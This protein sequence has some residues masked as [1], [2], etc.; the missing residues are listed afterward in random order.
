[1]ELKYK[2]K[3]EAHY[4]YIKGEYEKD[5]ARGYSRQQWSYSLWELMMLIQEGK[6][7][8]EGDN[9]ETKND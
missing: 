2:E 3:E 1:M 8:P 9:D 6:W 5:Q 7:N 4:E